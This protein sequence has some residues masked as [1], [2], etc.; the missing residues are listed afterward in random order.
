MK[1]FIISFF[2]ILL[3]FPIFAQAGDKHYLSDPYWNSGKAE[4]QVYQG[5]IKKY[6]ISKHLNHMK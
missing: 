4:F 5:K 1:Q 2:I 3:L 6:K